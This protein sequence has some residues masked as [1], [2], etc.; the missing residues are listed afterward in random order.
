MPAI[1]LEES[2]N[3]YS[4]AD[5]QPAGSGGRG[6]FKP[7]PAPGGSWKEAAVLLASAASLLAP[8]AKQASSRSARED[9]LCKLEELER[10]LR[11][12]E[13]D[14][15]APQSAAEP[16]PEQTQSAQLNKEAAGFD[17][18]NFA[19]PPAARGSGMQAGASGRHGEPHA[20]GPSS[21]GAIVKNTGVV[22]QHIVELTQAE[23][24]F[25]EEPE[26]RRA[27]ELSNAAAALALRRDVAASGFAS[28]AAIENSI[29]ELSAE[30][31]ETRRAV[32]A[33]L[34]P[35][36]QA[37]EQ[38][39]PSSG[40][41]GAI[42]EAIASLRA[43]HEET[44]SRTR[45]AWT[46]IQ[47]SLDHVAGLCARLEAAMTDKAALSQSAA[48]AADDPFA[49]LLA[50]LAQMPGEHAF[51]VAAA[52]SA[53]PGAG[54]SPQGARA[55]SPDAFGGAD[56]SGFLIEPGAGRPGLE[57][58]H[59]PPAAFTPLPGPAQE[60]GPGASRAEFIAAA[61]H[62]ART[63]Q[64]QALGRSGRAEDGPGIVT[65]GQNTGASFFPAGRGLL[66]PRLPLAIGAHIAGAI[67]LAAV[68]G[69]QPVFT[70]V[71]ELVPAFV[72]QFYGAAQSKIPARAENA[73]AP[74][75]V[76][77]TAAAPPPPAAVLAEA[78]SGEAGAAVVSPRPNARHIQAAQ[79]GPFA[80]LAQPVDAAGPG[81]K[82]QP[83]GRTILGSDAIV[84][85]ALL[86]GKQLAAPAQESAARPALPILSLNSNSKGEAHAPPAS[87]SV[88]PASPAAA[89]SGNP[90][91]D[92]LA[93]AKTGDS[94]AQFELAAVY[95]A[96]ASAPRNLALA[97]QWY[98]KVAGQG[99]AIAEYR[100]ASLYEKG[101]GVA[102]DLGRAKELYQRAAEKGNIRAMHNL[103]VIAAE[104]SEGKPNY[105]GAA[106]WFGKAA[107]YGIK[108]SQYNLAVLLARGLGVTKDLV[109]SYTWFA[110]VAAAGDE[111][112][113]RK[114]DEVATRLTS[115]ELATAKAAAAAFVPR[116]PDREANEPASPPLSAGTAKA[117]PPPAKA[118]LSG[119]LD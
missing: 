3:A 35:N 1:S 83:S 95:A 89:P 112:A 40:T 16:T 85:A 52:N 41:N 116:T 109:R 37:P 111:E 15:Q 107:G 29:R 19:S 64:L 69:A 25:A 71:N 22:H 42:L 90:V 56:M 57:D 18:Q 10:K 106:L 81:G 54:Q 102:K 115:S 93:R 91:E 31:E 7:D 113:A 99:H 5:P 104:G 62:A 27:A 12:H 59:A 23:L 80:P 97:V 108:D 73:P 13:N 72:K 100:L 75:S 105:T 39:L 36:G 17:R 11:E 58:A 2:P 78:L 117:A 101:H 30:V 114:R 26:H 79:A 77:G 98:E 47:T 53:R 118:N 86:P 6:S 24:G 67:I 61:W 34:A 96:D 60:T 63:A 66:S 65:T 32:A 49:P 94:A 110:I 45:F 82:T 76:R 51:Q 14:G 21:T 68:L 28:L 84:A 46:S 103:G 70:R 48:A 4:A 92:L 74:G 87:A 9:L 55:G 50:R 38:G 119:I 43:L 8:E 88:P 33:M 20:P 44:A